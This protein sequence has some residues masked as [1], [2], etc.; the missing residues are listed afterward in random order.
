MKGHDSKIRILYLHE[1]VRMGGAEISLMNLLKNI[2]RTV[3]DPLFVL[4]EEGRFSAVLNTL[5]VRVV[6]LPMPPLRKVVGIAGMIRALARLIEYEEI[7]I[8]HSNS[9]RTHM[10]GALAARLGRVPIVWH[11]RNLVTNELFDPDRLFSFLPDRI[12]CNSKAV[13]ERFI[14]RGAM[15]PKIRV[16]YNGV[17]IESFKPDTIAASA[18]RRELGIGPDEAVVTITSRFDRRKG[19]EV[20]FKAAAIVLNRMP[21]SARKLRLL[22]VG[23][24]VFDE[25]EIRFTRLREMAQREKISDSVVFTPFRDDMPA[26]Y[27]ASDIVVLPSVAEACSRVLLEAM[28]CARPVVAVNSGGTPEMVAD[29]ETGF[30]VE[31]G[32]PETLAQKIALLV[33]DRILAAKMGAAGRERVR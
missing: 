10:Y 21:K 24:V 31:T 28:A 7:R 27:A 17:D 29:N 20:L 30:L 2:D 15:P 1:T 26:V 11:Q 13:A 6:L 33:N 19:H 18:V 5:G 16:I 22:V 3:F 12:I 14:R 4:P 32:D 9:I 8:V 25:E 23:G